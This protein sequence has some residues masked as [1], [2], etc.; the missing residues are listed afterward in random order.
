MQR[1]DDGVL[2]VYGTGSSCETMALVYTGYDGLRRDVQCNHHR[3]PQ[4]LH[5]IRMPVGRLHVIL[6]D[7]HV[8]MLSS[9]IPYGTSDGV[10][11]EG[12]GI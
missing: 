5:C 11:K 1:G 3:E 7:V 4:R 9:N 2:R 6:R 8:F 12:T 10:K